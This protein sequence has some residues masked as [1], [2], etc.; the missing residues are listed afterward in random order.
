MV[1]LK[2]ANRRG[3]MQRPFKIVV[4]DTLAL[5]PPMG[6]NSWYIHYHRVTGPVMRQAADQ[7][8][9][10]G[11]ADSLRPEPSAQAGWR[12]RRR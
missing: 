12:R 5:T 3:S 9:A 6:W 1:T 7:M 10:S 11:M 8:I 2:A 4:G